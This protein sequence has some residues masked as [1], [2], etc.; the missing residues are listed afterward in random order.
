MSTR[1][2]RRSNYKSLIELEKRAKEATPLFGE[3]ALDDSD[4]QSFDADRHSDDGEVR[5]SIVAVAAA[6]TK[7]AKASPVF[8]T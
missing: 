3:E 2:S 4:D 5:S 8:F 1:R 7:N 6:K